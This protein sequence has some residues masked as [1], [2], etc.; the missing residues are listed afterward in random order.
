MNVDETAEPG[1][2]ADSQTQFGQEARDPT[3]RS[4][5]DGISIDRS[6]QYEATYDRRI[7]ALVVDAFGAYRDKD[8]PRA[9]SLYLD[10]LHSEPLHPDALAGMAA[11]YQ[12][13][14]RDELALATYEKLLHLQPGNTL[15]AS[16]VLSLRA[17]GDNRGGESDLKHLLQR[18]PD[19]HHLQFTLGTIYVG[20][21]RWPEARQ[22]FQAAHELAPLN[23]DY[24]YNLA[25]SLERL[26]ALRDARQHY[27]DALR[28]TGDRSNFD[29][30][31]LKS[32][33]VTLVSRLTEPS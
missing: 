31:K 7:Y 21:G 17:T 10:V 20:E 12:K 8:Y 18:F 1:T 13:T 16:A 30:D 33:L 22:A 23:P 25:V 14:S 29:Q 15:A 9:E 26:G 3:V 6:N 27:E 5:S 11:V 4:V 28:N 19:A 24:S 32:H 2:I